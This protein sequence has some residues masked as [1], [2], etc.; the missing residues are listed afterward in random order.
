MFFFPKNI[1]YFYLGVPSHLDPVESPIIISLGPSKAG[2][3]QET[4]VSNN[5]IVLTKLFILIIFLTI[6]KLTAIFF[7]FDVYFTYAFI[8]NFFFYYPNKL[9][10]TYYLITT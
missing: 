6:T 2:T 1:F 10:Y 9:N 8:D 5:F 3:C 7:Y 4:V